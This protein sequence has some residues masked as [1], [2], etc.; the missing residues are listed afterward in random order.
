[1][2]NVKESL[3]ACM[4]LDGATAAALVEIPTGLCLG[5]VGGAGTDLE[6]AAAASAALANSQSMRLIKPGGRIEDILITEGDSFHIIRPVRKEADLLLYVV[7]SRGA[8]NLGLARRLLSAV[9][10]ELTVG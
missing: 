9:E 1:M 10:G 2:A 6:S 5:C 8:G 4:R 7:V 3:A